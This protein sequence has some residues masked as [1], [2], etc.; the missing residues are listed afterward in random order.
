MYMTMCFHSIGSIHDGCGSFGC[1]TVRLIG[2]F[3]MTKSGT[4][5][6][7]VCTGTYPTVGVKY[8]RKLRYSSTF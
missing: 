7:D 3:V 6:R 4:M 1:P 2:A 8:V 5:S